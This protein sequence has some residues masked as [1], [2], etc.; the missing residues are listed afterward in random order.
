MAVKILDSI[1]TVGGRLLCMMFGSRQSRGQKISDSGWC[2]TETA[3]CAR[4]GAM[5][6]LAETGHGEFE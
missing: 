2:A 3:A 4:V 5:M 6:R 1:F